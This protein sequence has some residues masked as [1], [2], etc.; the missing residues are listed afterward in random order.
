MWAVSARRS[1]SAARGPARC[2]PRARR[3]SRTWASTPRTN[4][5]R[6]IAR[7]RSARRRPVQPLCLSCNRIAKARASRVNGRT[8]VTYACECGGTGDSPI[9]QG[10]LNWRL[11]WPALWK[12]LKVDIEPFGKDHATPGG[13]RD[14]CK[15]AARVLL[16]FEPPFGIPYEWVGYAEKGVDLGDMDS[17]DFKGFWPGD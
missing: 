10:K 13:S 7:W 2:G 16:G 11:E 6:A 12:V 4:G 9:E 17:S 1:C 14:S 3:S 5:S 15:E 8:S